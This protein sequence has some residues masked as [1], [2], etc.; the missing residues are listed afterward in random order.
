[1]GLKQRLLQGQ[2]GLSVGI[3]PGDTPIND[4]QSGFVQSNSPSL[5]YEDET[6]GQPD[7]GSALINTLDNTGLDNTLGLHDTN[8]LFPPVSTDYPALSKGE[9]GGVSSQYSQVYGPDN[10]YLSSVSIEDIDSPQLNTLNKTSLDNT[11]GGSISNVPI[12]NSLSAPND[13][14][15]LTKGEFGGS[16]SQYSSP[17]NAENTYLNS[18][19]DINTT[20]QTSTLNKTSLDNTNN[21]SISTIPIP[22]NISYPNDYPQPTSG[23]FGGSPSQY[24][25]PYNANNPYLSSINTISVPAN[26]TQVNTL[27]NT[28]LDNSNNNFDPTAFRPDEIGASTNYGNLPNSP[29]VQLGEFGGAP[30]QYVDQ[31]TPNGTTYIEQIDSPDFVGIQ[32]SS[33]SG[34]GLSPNTSNAAP[35]VFIVPSPDTI[36][37]YPAENVTGIVGGAAQQFS[38]L[39]GETKPYYNYMKTNFGAS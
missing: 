11:N 29:S 12:P 14:P 17:Y 25:S 37:T 18:I 4:P 7:N 22:D 24:E 3:F 19:G 35:T 9:Y 36:T 34:S 16:P 15:Q 30:S 33:F 26:N 28:G 39:W 8:K 32:S 10:T 1:M 38:Q 31:Y 23:K 20:P 2:T 5:T 27:D 6:L 13:Y 21:N